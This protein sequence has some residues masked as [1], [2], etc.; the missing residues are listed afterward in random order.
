[1]AIL[2]DFEALTP[3]ILCRVLETVEGGGIIVLLLHSMDSLQQLYSMTMDAHTNLR[4]ETHID[5]EPRFNERFI[6]SLKECSACLV[7]DDELNILPISAHAKNLKPLEVRDAS[8][9]LEVR[10]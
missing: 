5:T 3:N 9:T 2:Q 7:V 6:L 4:T 10:K 8:D 1:M